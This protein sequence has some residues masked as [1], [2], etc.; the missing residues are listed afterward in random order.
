MNKDVAFS[1]KKMNA[2]REYNDGHF[3]LDSSYQQHM[4]LVQWVGWYPLSFLDM[5]EHMYGI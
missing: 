5:H 4:I 1:Q 2:K 3:L